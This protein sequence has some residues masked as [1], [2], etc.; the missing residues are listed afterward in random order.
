MITVEQLG[1]AE[2]KFLGKRVKI[3]EYVGILQFLGYNKYLP[4]WGLC[5]TVDRMP[6]Q[7][8]KLEEITLVE[9]GER[10]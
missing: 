5:A 1:T 8:V 9:D 10:I 4:S 7:N 3:R 6:I 2:K